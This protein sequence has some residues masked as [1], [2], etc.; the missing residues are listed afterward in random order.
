M[1]VNVVS[2]LRHTTVHRMFVL[3]STDAHSVIVLVEVIVLGVDGLL[4]FSMN[5]HSGS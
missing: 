4:I 5:Q 1:W 3:I 2:G